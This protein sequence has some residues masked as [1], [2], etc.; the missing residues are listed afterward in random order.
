[1]KEFRLLSLLLVLISWACNAQNI[2]KE[3]ND[4]VWRVQLEAM[5]SNQA[6]KFMSVMSEDVMQVSYSRQAIRNKEEFFRQ[7]V[8]TYQRIVD[9]KLRRSMD[10]R[11]LNRIAADSSAFEDG[12]Y[13]YELVN[14][15]QEKQIYYGYF[16]V[17]LRKEGGIWKVL[18]DYDA[19]TYHGLP[20]TRDVFEN[21]K[22][23]DAY[24]N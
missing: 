18:V 4:Q 16:Q 17:A 19:E 20:V 23:L 2:Q 3:I 21:A 5:H 14:E 24:Y 12:F 6:E 8:S 11:F 22:T 10:F 1:M 13:K 7:A 9:R 15:K